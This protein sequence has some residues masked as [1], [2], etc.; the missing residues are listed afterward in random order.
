MI[1]LKGQNRLGGGGGGL[2]TLAIFGHQGIIIVVTSG[3]H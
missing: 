3:V 1:I 2:E